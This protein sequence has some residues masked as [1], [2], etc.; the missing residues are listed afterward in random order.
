M[1]ENKLTEDQVLEIQE[2]YS[3]RKYTISMLSK[4]YN[5]SYSI[6]NLVVIHKY[7]PD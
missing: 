7:L 3:S 5:V 4:E 2:K 6:I 1:I